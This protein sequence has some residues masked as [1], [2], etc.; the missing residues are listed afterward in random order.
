[1]YII[2]MDFIENCQKNS[3]LCITAILVGVVVTLL[4]LW[5]YLKYGSERFTDPR[6]LDQATQA[7]LGYW[8][9]NNGVGQEH[10][11]AKAKNYK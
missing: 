2:I 6:D 9:T 4:I 10:M 1:L 11:K 8:M 5:L 7:L 3:D